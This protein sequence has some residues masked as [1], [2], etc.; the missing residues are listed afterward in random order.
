MRSRAVPNVPGGVEIS[1]L[2][3]GRE[4]EQYLLFLMCRVELKSPSRWGRRR[5]ASS[6]VPNVPG[7]VE[8]N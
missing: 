3:P 2:Y 1:K 8:I 4:I 6:Q 5:E 7:G